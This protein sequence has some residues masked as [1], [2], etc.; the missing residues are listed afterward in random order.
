MELKRAAFPRFYF[1]SSD[2]L[3]DILANSTNLDIIQGHLKTCFD[4]IVKLEIGDDGVEILAMQSNEKELVKF[5]KTRNARGQIEKWLND[6][7]E[8]MIATLKFLLNT[9]NKEYPTMDR[10]N[11]VLEK[12]G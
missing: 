11:F 9:A 5:K 2:E 3:I 1:L 7:Q 4:N 12:K 8:E 6:V 10:K